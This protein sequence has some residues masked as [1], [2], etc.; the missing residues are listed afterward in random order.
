V[1]LGKVDAME[2]TFLLKGVNGIL[3]SFQDFHSA[4]DNSAHVHG[5]LLS[6]CNLPDSRRR[7]LIEA[8]HRK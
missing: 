7:N 8:L 3:S 1:S 4:L 6:D 2:G 5:H